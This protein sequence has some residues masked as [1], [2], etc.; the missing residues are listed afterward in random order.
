MGFKAKRKAQNGYLCP[1]I[2]DMKLLR[3]SLL[4]IEYSGVII[5]NIRG[6]T[7]C[8]TKE[9]FSPQLFLEL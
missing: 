4:K 2:L 5:S 1:A 9:V 8:S 6:K 7:A 3:P